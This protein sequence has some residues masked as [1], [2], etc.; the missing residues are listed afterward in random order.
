MA[1]RKRI[2]KAENGT[3]SAKKPKVNG[4]I[5]KKKGHSD[6][7][8]DGA[9]VRIKMKNFVTYDECEVMQG[10]HLN[11]LVGP[12]GTGK[13]S[14]V[15][16]LCLGLAGHPRLLGRASEVG[17]FVK[18]GASQ[19]MTEVE[20]YNS[21][22]HNYIITRDIYREGNRSVWKINGKGATMKEVQDLTARLNVQISNL[23]QFLPQDKVVEFA[24]MTQQ[25]LLMATEAAVGPPGMQSD[26]QELIDLRK[27]EKE[28][29]LSL[30]EKNSHLE[31]LQE[32]NQRLEHEV[33]RYKERER[34]M[35]IV[36]LLKKKRPWAEYE[37]A[38]KQFVELKTK[39][40]DAKKQLDQ[41]R[42]ENA[43]MEQ[44]LNAIVQHLCQLDRN[45]KQQAE[46]GS[47]TH[48]KAKAKSDQL[49][50][51]V[52]KIEEQ[53][54]HLKDMQD[55]EK[56]RH[57]KISD[58]ERQ[59][60]GYETELERLPDPAEL[61][62]KI[63]EISGNA[64]QLNRQ[65]TA[66]QQ[67]GQQ[68]NRNR[69][70]LKLQARDIQSRLHRLEDMRNQRLE[71][72]RT[73]FKDTYNAV[74]W[75]RDNQDK[76]SQPVHE[77]IMLQVN[78]KNIN[79]AKYL[80]K[81]INANDMRSFV[82]ESREDMN[83][84]MDEVRDKQH[85]KVNGVVPPNEPLSSFRP[86]RSIVE[87]RRWGFKC[88]LQ[89]LFT[90]PEA[91]TKYLC[92]TY[93]VHDIPLGDESTAKNSDQVIDESGLRNFFTPSSRYRVKFSKYGNKEK[94]TSV[95]HIRDAKI[96]NIAVDLER[97]RALEEEL[98]EIQVQHQSSN[99]R[100]AEIVDK[101]KGLAG[102]L[103]EL[104]N[105]KKT[106][107][108]QLQRRKTLGNQMEA[109]QNTLASV[110]REAPDLKAKE[111]RVEHEIDKINV[112]RTRLA[113]DFKDAIKD[114]MAVCKERVLSSFQHAK[115]NMEK[116]KLENQCRESQDNY[117]R[118]E[119]EYRRAQASLEAQKSKARNLKQVAHQ[120]TGIPMGED[121]PAS[122]KEA[123][124]ILPDTLD[125][126]DER[127][128]EEQARAECNYQ[129]DPNVIKEYESRD[130]E[131]KSMSGQV[132]AQESNLAAK[133]QQIANLKERWLVPL[134]ELLAKINVK[135]GEF[136]RMMGCAGEVSLSTDQGEKEYDRYGVQI[137]V[138]FRAKDSLHVLTPF[139]QS[140][141]ER[142]VSTM[143]FLMALQELTHCPFRVVDEINQGMDPN[144]ERRVF[145][146]VVKTACKAHT[147]QYF[148]ITP[149]L[150][151]DLDYTD[152]MTILCVF[153]GH[154][155]LPHSEWNMDRFLKRRRLALSC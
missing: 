48:R 49:E 127:I 64:R 129:T 94:S 11:V 140:G 99:E 121:V 41:C 141:G 137:K 4:V 126:I 31:R 23:C 58:L 10:P 98:Q 55:E 111:A 25:Q 53:Q 61:Q 73:R 91:V 85:L 77:P 86:R 13:S 76:F 89:D 69:E 46:K 142:S 102:Q 15:C 115:V 51:L 153:N 22:G 21:S 24:K 146:L 67:E 81:L 38:R 42:R 95:E 155:M 136:F 43:P 56:R 60:Q 74:M 66:L 97:K 154:W 82:F 107:S 68:L 84:F 143:L 120:L 124:K 117:A 119:D 105:S 112:K 88:Y 26:H 39:R 92:E 147:A 57:K 93:R 37:E 118:L 52:D 75:L 63:E 71:L 65:I 122:L 110:Q 130:K 30:Q 7:F 44:Q 103:E 145:D 19:G 36:Q 132:D 70:Q 87:L 79:D 144:N 14:V 114:C 18:H 32:Q 33:Q 16:A 72:L 35:E 116:N 45:M 2:V 27:A 47:E 3:L 106:L 109:K 34:H 104:R 6:E 9:I 134:Q 1:S 149:K 101:E 62:P 151:P 138:K 150:L 123:F 80:E 131:I 59:I 83:I 113:E 139:H 29:E 96:L 100:Y 108:S 152:R 20:L 148:L 17:E 78:M 54:N 133:Q 8:V 135:Y 28:I 40:E 50:A 12:N 125:E 90:A 128:N 5:I